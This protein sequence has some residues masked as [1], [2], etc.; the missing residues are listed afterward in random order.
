[1]VAWIIQSQ[2]DGMSLV[3]ACKGRSACLRVFDPDLGPQICLPS[4]GKFIRG[5]V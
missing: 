3:Y 5:L 4:V 2:N 1:M